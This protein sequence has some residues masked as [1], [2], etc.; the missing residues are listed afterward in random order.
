MSSQNGLDDKTS[1]STSEFIHKAKSKSF[2]MEKKIIF[3]ENQPN[4]KFNQ[5]ILWPSVIKLP[6]NTWLFDINEILKNLEDT[7][8][9]CKKARSMIKYC[10]E[11]LY[12]C[13]KD[14]KTQDQCFLIMATL[15][16]RYW[17]LEGSKELLKLDTE[18]IGFLLLTIIITSCKVTE[19]HRKTYAYVETVLKRTNPTVTSATVMDKKKWYIRENLLNEE[20][21]FLA[22]MKFDFNIS[23]PRVYLESLFGYYTKFNIDNEDPIMTNDL[24]FKKQ[25]GII[26]RDCKSFITNASTQPIS[27]I[28]DG[29][30]FLQFS[31]IF[32]AYHFNKS[33]K[34]ESDNENFFRFTQGF[35]SRKFETVLTVEKIEYISKVLYILEKNFLNNKTN[36]GEVLLELTKE[37]IIDLVHSSDIKYEK[38][39]EDSEP[40]A[41]KQKIEDNKDVYNSVLQDVCG[42]VLEFF[43]GPVHTS[44]YYAIHIKNDVSEEYLEH[45]R[46]NITSTYELDAKINSMPKV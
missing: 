43:S 31:L 46:K 45:L 38:S 37:A 35:F 3:N 5:S 4:A 21:T 19:N 34:F 16:Y 41:K 28:C 6:E 36:K 2:M 30:D 12:K 11:I 1:Q 26:M 10:I 7:N 44:D 13:A 9:D 23:N 29:I 20:M 39:I 42:N 33:N 22:K 27:L 25:F 14:L 17:M 18:R 15:L 40:E 8:G 32:T 24:K